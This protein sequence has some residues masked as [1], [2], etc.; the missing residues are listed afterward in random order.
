MTVVVGAA[1]TVVVGTTACAM[2]VG[3]GMVLVLGAVVVFAVAVFLGAGGAGV[4]RGAAGV[5]AVAGVL[6]AAL[7]FVG[8]FAFTVSGVGGKGDGGGTTGC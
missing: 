2:A 7:D 3:V 8:T 5:L 6:G 1:R 4:L